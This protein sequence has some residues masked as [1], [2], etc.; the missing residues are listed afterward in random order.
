ML[1]YT[2]LLKELILTMKSLGYRAF[3][4][5]FMPENDCADY[6]TQLASLAAGRD[7]AVAKNATIYR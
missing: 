5:E 1:T 6:G 4:G 3:H 2:Y 7:Y